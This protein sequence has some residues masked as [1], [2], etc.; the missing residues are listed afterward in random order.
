MTISEQ[1]Q[2]NVVAVSGFAN[3]LPLSNVYV[4]DADHLAVFADTTALTYGVDYTVS[5]LQDGNGP[6]VTITS[7]ESFAGSDY[8]VVMH[9]PPL[10]Q[11]ADLSVGGQFGLVY[12]VALDAI[13]RRVQV[14]QERIART[15][16]LPVNADP[17][18]AITILGPDEGKVLLWDEDGNLANSEYGLDAVAAAAAAAAATATAAAATA[19][20]AASTATTA[21]GQAEYWA[22]QA[23]YWAAQAE[24]IAGIDLSIY[25]Q[26]SANLGDLTDLGDAWTNMGLGTAAGYSVAALPLSDAATTALGNKFDKAGGS[27]TGE[28]TQAM[29]T[30]YFKQQNTSTNTQFAVATNNGYTFF[31]CSSNAGYTTGTGQF[32]FGG[33]DAGAN[34]T[35]KV[36]YGGVWKEAWHD[37]NVA[38]RMG[39]VSLLS[40][41]TGSETVPITGASAL[42]RTTTG[43]IAALAGGAP[44]GQI[45]LFAA[46]SPPTGYLEADGSA[47]S[48]TTYATL[49][50]A[51]GTTFGSGDGSSTFN[52]PDLR[53]EFI[54]GWD[55][56]RGVDSG[57]A[58]GSAQSADMATHGHTGSLAS[59]GAH[60][61]TYYHSGAGIGSHYPQSASYTNT[62]SGTTSSAG[63]HTHTLTINDH[64]G[65]ETRPRNI[66]L[67]PCIKY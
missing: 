54:R 44:A 62:Y 9:T 26:R 27:I 38:A 24:A 61:H 2:R 63:S 35:V 21:A 65:T 66:A 19:T 40:P 16:T 6:E 41:L 29:A 48:R 53:G 30:P 42:R 60:T 47:V 10:D 15:A 20:G 46:N 56:G 8:F 59:N 12:E 23:E 37:G 7:P 39:A 18:T 45:M 50:A 5:N 55:N 28:V 4:E 49:F 36:L 64:T 43:A 33:Y 34:A 52:I 13:M 22:G 32:Y 11:G 25:M 17:A 67:L 57:R 51:I 14:L 58:F 1:A 31:Y 3:P